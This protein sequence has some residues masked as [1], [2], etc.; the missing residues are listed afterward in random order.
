[1]LQSD[2]DVIMFIIHELIYSLWLPEFAKHYI[3]LYKTEMWSE[4]EISVDRVTSD[5]SNKIIKIRRIYESSTKI[6]E[7]VFNGSW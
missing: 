7:Y 6:R 4:I 3:S 2:H 5:T 1:M